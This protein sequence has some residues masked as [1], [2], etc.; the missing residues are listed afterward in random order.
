MTEGVGYVGLDDQQP[1]IIVYPASCVN[2]G[3]GNQRTFLGIEG[4]EL[5]LYRQEIF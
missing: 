1:S 4:N 2:I 3:I 5:T